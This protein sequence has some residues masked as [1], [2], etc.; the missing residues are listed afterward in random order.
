MATP[1]LEIQDRI[2]VLQPDFNP[3]HSLASHGL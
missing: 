3:N 1:M 2:R